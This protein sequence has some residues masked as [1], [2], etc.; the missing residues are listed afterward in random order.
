MKKIN[1]K[2]TNNK[3]TFIVCTSDVSN[4]TPE[5]D[6]IERAAN[7]WRATFDAI[8]DMVWICDVD[9]NLERVNKSFAEAAGCVPKDLIGKKCYDI[10]KDAAKICVSCPHKKTIIT[11]RPHSSI[12]ATDGKY[13]EIST[14]PIIGEKNK[15]ISS[16]CVAHDITERRQMEEALQAAAHKWRTTFDGIGEAICLT[17]PSGIVVQCNQA[18][19]D[20]LGKQ[21]KEILGCS[22]S[23]IIINISK[24]PVDYSINDMRQNMKRQSFNL[25]VRKRW[26]NAVA[27]P[28]FDENNDFQGVALI[29]SD[30]TENKRASEKLKKIYRLEKQLREQAEAEM[31]RRIE[32]TR[33]LVHELKTPLTPV[34]ASSELLAEELKVEPWLSLAKNINSGANN[35]NRRIDELLDLA[36]GEVGILK[37]N[38][39]QIETSRLFQEVIQYMT[40]LAQAKKQQLIPNFR[41][42]P[43]IWADEDRLRQILFN[44]I[45][46]SLKFTPEE[47]TITLQAGFDEDYL[48]IEVKDTGLGISYAD[49]KLLFQPYRLLGGDHRRFSGLGVGLVLSKKLIELH[50]G[51]IWVI[52]SKGHG[53]T[54]AF[55]LPINVNSKIIK[56]GEQQ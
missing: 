44:L 35:L 5:K 24:T 6:K 26:Y 43:V 41:D 13:F 7:E 54:F 25:N 33:A 46:N 20:L 9:C 18:F 39:Q 4:L 56:F 15:T 38:L 48:T 17:D 14:A 2:I 23:D 32:F 37:L 11:G 55:K 47:G 12:C 19:A 34:L 21:F 22:T 29:L 10:L 28:I 42:L 8:R 30:I 1:H 27:D 52:S 36:R 53:S 51:K 45:N 3:E 50:G 49:Q 16:V 40:P 31:K